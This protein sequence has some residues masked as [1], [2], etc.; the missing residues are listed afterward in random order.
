MDLLKL[1]CFRKAIATMD[2][3]K[4]LETQFRKKVFDK[5]I[6]LNRVW[7][8][9]RPSVLNCFCYGFRLTHYRKLTTRIL[10]TFLDIVRRRS[11]SPDRSFWICSKWV[12]SLSIYTVSNCLIPC[13]YWYLQIA[14]FEKTHRFFVFLRKM[15]E[16]KLSDE[17]I[18]KYYCCY[19]WCGLILGPFH[20]LTKKKKNRLT[21]SNFG[22]YPQVYCVS[23]KM[24]EKLRKSYQIKMN[25]YL[26]K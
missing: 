19:Y 20:Y 6:A 11:L 22:E 4:S 25:H 8:L 5:Q 14:I 15:K 9:C 2:W 10:S 16:K 18:I 1:T 12:N 3:S 23:K 26:P 13:H 17:E 7:V 21:N 24:K